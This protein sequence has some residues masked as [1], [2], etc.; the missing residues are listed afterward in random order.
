MR[1]VQLRR[2]TKTERKDQMYGQGQAQATPGEMALKQKGYIMAPGEK[3]GNPFQI[4]P[5]MFE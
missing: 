4:Y 5:R 1:A 3:F 2:V